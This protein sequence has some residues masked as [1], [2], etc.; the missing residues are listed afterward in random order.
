MK[1][2]QNLL[3]NTLLKGALESITSNPCTKGVQVVSKSPAKSIKEWEQQQQI[4]LP[5][6][7]R[8]FYKA[9]DGFTI[10]WETKDNKETGFMHIKSVCQL[11]LASNCRLPSFEISCSP[12]Y[13]EIYLVYPPETHPQVWFREAASNLWFPLA[14]NFSCFFRLLV[15]HF[16]ISGWPMFCTA[17]VVEGTVVGGLCNTTLDWLSM[18]CPE[19]AMLYLGHVYSLSQS[20]LVASGR[21]EATG[22]TEETQI[23]TFSIE[24]IQHKVERMRN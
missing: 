16:G 17:R 23:Q 20:C 24:N 4:S 8:R 21:N 6:D 10:K 22:D 1:T 19:R 12:P 2:S 11:K 18:Y 3:S 13:G 15:A 9:Q 14:P 5:E 7:L